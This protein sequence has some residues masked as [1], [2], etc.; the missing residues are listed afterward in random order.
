[1][2]KVICVIL[3]VSLMVVSVGCGKKANNGKKNTASTED[4]SQL[5]STQEADANGQ[6]DKD[7]A[8]T[9]DTTKEDTTQPASA[10]ET[11][12]S[13]EENKDATSTEDASKPASEQASGNE[14]G[15]GNKENKDATPAKDSPKSDSKQETASKDNSSNKDSKDTT[16][17]KDTP[18]ADSTPKTDGNVN[19][20]EKSQVLPFDM[21]LWTRQPEWLGNPSSNALIKEVSVPSPFS[22][23]GKGWRFEIPE[24]GAGMKWTYNPPKDPPMNT[25]DT[26]YFMVRYRAEN[27]TNSS[28]VAHQDFLVFI[29]D[30]AENEYI[31][32]RLNEIKD[33]GQW[34]TA[35]VSFPAIDVLMFVVQVQAGKPNAYV[36]IGSIGFYS[37]G[38]KIQ[39]KENESPVPIS[40]LA[41]G[42]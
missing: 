39:L 32:V 8:S 3:I 37:G 24:E 26:P 18:K 19:A 25:A 7:T 16:P 31:P 42:N 23:N 13:K 28:G 38:Y 2:K 35:V 9:E 12:V 36:E 14:N 40:S 33:D 29:Y 17:V 4:T 5:A 41:S 27:L 11:D 15:A 21:N 10:Q 34:R 22:E 1:M 30:V 6:E 20:G